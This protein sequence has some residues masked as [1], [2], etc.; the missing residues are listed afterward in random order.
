MNF[1]KIGRLVNVN[2]NIAGV[3]LNKVDTKKMASNE[4]YHGYYTDSVYGQ[5]EES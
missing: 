3:V 5:R 2:A 1:L 4:Y